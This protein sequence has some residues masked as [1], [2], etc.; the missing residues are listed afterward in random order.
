V[1]HQ[2]NQTP[3]VWL[4][5]DSTTFKVS[6]PYEDIG[7]RNDFYAQRIV[8]AHA[9]VT[10]AMLQLIWIATVLA[11]VADSWAIARPPFF[12]IINSEYVI[13]NDIWNTTIGSVLARKLY[14]RGIELVGRGRGHFVSH[15]MKRSLFRHR[16]DN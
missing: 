10:A 11:L 2:S 16:S 15:S 12:K 13:G 4:L 3:T 1:Q 5:R 7:Y 8:F 9:I 6:D 14:Y